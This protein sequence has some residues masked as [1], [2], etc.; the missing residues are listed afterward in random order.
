MVYV[1]LSFEK[2]KGD[3]TDPYMKDAISLARDEHW[4]FLR[5]SIS[6]TFSSG[7]MRQVCKL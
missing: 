5:S 3:N 2:A 6:P 1:L 4:K 7:K